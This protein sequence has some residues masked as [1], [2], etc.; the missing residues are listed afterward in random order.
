M[1]NLFPELFSFGVA[2]ADLQVVGEKTARESEH[3]EETMWSWFARTSGK[4]HQDTGPELGVDRYNRWQEDIELMRSLGVRTYR[5]SIS[6]SR[7]LT[8][9]G[10]LNA[11]AA[12]WYEAYF[13]ALKKAGIS[14]HATLYHWELPQFLNEQGGW[15]NRIM[16]DWL[17][18]HAEAVFQTLGEYISEYYILNEPWCSAFL[19]YHLGIHA[20]GETSLNSG[21]L[22]A[23]NLLLAQGVAFEKLKSLDRN[24]KVSTV[25]NLASCYAAT[26]SPEDIRAARYADIY[27]NAWFLDP[28]FNGRYPEDGM[29]LY[30]SKLPRFGKADMAL[31][32][33]GPRLNALGINYYMGHTVRL[34]ERAE[35]RFAGVRKAGELTNDLGWPIYVA[36]AYQNGLYDLLQQVWFNYRA[37]G[38][39]KIYITENGMAQAPAQEAREPMDDQRRVEYLKAHTAQVAA[40]IARG[41]PVQAYFLWT[42]MDNY[43]WAEGH[44]PESCFGIVH[45]DRRT[46]KRTRK[47]SAVWYSQTLLKAPYQAKALENIVET[48]VSP[49]T[50]TQAPAVAPVVSSNKAGHI[51]RRPAIVPVAP[52]KARREVEV[53]KVR[54][55]KAKKPASKPKKGKG[56]AS[57]RR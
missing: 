8:K 29:E 34:D 12:R 46:M 27:H 5:T 36:P 23:H 7:L 53:V 1:R 55:Q 13:Q 19:G 2:D 54:E 20:P 4:C 17:S 16:V 43:E 10:D 30:S 3:S 6:M 41:I 18:K 26:P 11:K 38:L 50:A 15:K 44:R 42:L 37:A 28:I 39:Q 52:V 57:A 21:L 48:R 51:L 35:T 24:L 25:L 45:V 49:V 9:S 56:R 47:D 33:I 32:Q 40:A 31:M 14:I 22:A